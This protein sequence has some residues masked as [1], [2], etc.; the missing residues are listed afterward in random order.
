MLLAGDV[1]GTKTLLGLYEPDAARPIARRTRRF[2]TLDFPNLGA[3]IAEFIGETSAPGTI[4]SA[5]FGLAGPVHGTVC[6]LTNVPWRVDATELAEQFSI[7]R[8]L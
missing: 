7:P 2:P 3:M 5:A 4:E 1:G 6:Q 8:V